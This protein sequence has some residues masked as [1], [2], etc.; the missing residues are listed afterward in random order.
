MDL[1]QL[2]AERGMDGVLEY[3]TPLIAE[4]EKLVTS[5]ETPPPAAAGE[6]EEEETENG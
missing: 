5:P 4:L 1:K 2:Y 6:E 3:L